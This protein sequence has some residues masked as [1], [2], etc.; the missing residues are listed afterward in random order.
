MTQRNDQRIPAKI[1]ALRRQRLEVLALPAE[2]ALERILTAEEPTALVH[3]FPEQDFYFLAHDIGPD[4][5]LP[6]LKLAS[7]RQWEYLLDLETWQRDRFDPFALTLWFDRLYRA[8]ARRTVRWLLEKQ[9]DL[10][11]QYLFSNIEVKVREHDQDPSEFGPDFFSVDGV[12][13]VRVTGALMAPESPLGDIERELVRGFVIRLLESIAAVDHISLQKIL[14]EAAYLVPN[15]TEEELYRRKNVRLAERG[16]MPFDEAVGVYQPLGPEQL[17][18]RPRK[19]MPRSNAEIAMPVPIYP[20]RMIEE[21]NLFAKAIAQVESGPLLEQLQTE[22]AGLC[23]RLIVADHAPMR[24]KEDLRKTVKKASGYLTLGL[25]TVAADEADA[26]RMAA[27]I[28]RHPLVDL[29]RVGYGQVLKL[30]RRA[31]KWL[32]DAWFASRGLSLTF[33]GERRMG[34]LGGL[35]IK[36]PLYFDN[37]ATGRLYREF[38]SPA[39]VAVT[40]TVLTEIIAFDQLLAL[41]DIRIEPPLPRR[42]LTWQNL[43]LTLWALDRSVAGQTAPRPLRLSEFRRFYEDLWLESAPPRRLR[44]EVRKDFLRWLCKRSGLHDYEI[45]ARL[46]AALEKL[47]GDIEDEFGRISA[48]DIDP[49]FVQMFI[50]ER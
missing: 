13:F 43:L 22:F 8:D 1:K 32:D 11:Q 5:S 34:V 3:S 19:F 2:Q 15:E 24:S 21:G 14:L 16:F 45:G 47:F 40:D 41:S 9:A 20:S 17:A 12:F 23:N 28:C 27:L 33:W 50:L 4:D 49:R 42:L 31:Q 30:K 25:Q 36:K 38:G 48:G 35:L 7:E 26:G 46:G 39:D 44:P 6:L 10:L 37:Y 18:E 29:F